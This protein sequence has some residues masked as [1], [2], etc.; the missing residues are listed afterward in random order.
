MKNIVS[1][2]T[3]VRGPGIQLDG[4]TSLRMFKTCFFLSVFREMTPSHGFYGPDG[5]FR[6]MQKREKGT[7][8]KRAER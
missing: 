2:N 6:M 8:K 3:K 7:L 1:K 4:E 5:K